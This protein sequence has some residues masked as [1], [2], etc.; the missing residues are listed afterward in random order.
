MAIPTLAFVGLTAGSRTGL[1]APLS[2]ARPWLR[3]QLATFHSTAQESSA[4]SAQNARLDC[5]PR[6]T[7]RAAASGPS[8]EPRLPPTW[9]IDCASPGRPPDAIRATREDSG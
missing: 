9:N 2:R 4:S 7:T 5:P 6:P 3:Y 1:A 8:A